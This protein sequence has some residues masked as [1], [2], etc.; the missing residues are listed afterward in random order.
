MLDKPKSKINAKRVIM[1]ESVDVPLAAEKM[2]FSK[3]SEQMFSKKTMLNMVALGFILKIL[4]IGLDEKLISG[5]LPEKF[6]DENLAAIKAGYGLNK[7]ESTDK[8]K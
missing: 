1:D 4:G 7:A 3:I 2:P 6:L 5:I 8:N